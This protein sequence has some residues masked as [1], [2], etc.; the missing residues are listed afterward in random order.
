MNNIEYFKNFNMGCEIEICGEFIYESMREMY[1]FKSFYNHFHINKILYYGSIGIERLQ[2]I[3]LSMY[4]LNTKEDFDNPPKMLFEHNHTALQRR[5]KEATGLK[6]MRNHNKLLNVFE[7]YYNKHRYGEFQIGYSSNS[8]GIL[9]TNYFNEITNVNYSIDTPNNPCDIQKIIKLYINYLGTISWQYFSL[10]R[11]KATELSIYTDE[12]TTLSNS[13]K[14]FYTSKDEKMFER[15]QL[16]SL[17][18]KELIIYLSKDNTK[19]N[20]N[21]IT[22]EIEA[23]DFDPQM[24]NEY[25]TN[26]TSFKASDDLTEAV[27]SFYDD[28]D[29]LSDKRKRKELVNLIGDRYVILD[30]DDD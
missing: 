4:L 28:I 19:T 13:I 23:I 20:I 15:I 16:E 9:F 17:A 30:C 11:E 18:L 2:K 21:K 29:N 26:I 25:L 14:V 10:I 5:I 7:D 6:L 24:I 3:V 22:D 1:S 27:E 8:L 12:L